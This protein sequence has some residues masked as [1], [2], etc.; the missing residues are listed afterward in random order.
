M[1][2][3]T[4][5]GFDRANYPD[6]PDDKDTLDQGAWSV[7]FDIDWG[8]SQ[9][10]RDMCNEDMRFVM[11][12]GGQ[13]E[14]FLGDQFSTNRPRM[15]MDRT[16]ERVNT[17]M[18][19]YAEAKPSVVFGPATGSNTSTD[20]C[21]ILNGLFR[22]DMRRNNGYYAVYNAVHEAVLGGMGA[23]RVRPKFEDEED[24]TNI[25]QNICFE[26]IHSAYSSV[27]WDANAKRYDK[28]D[29]RHCNIITFM[30]TSAFYERYGDNV[31]P[32]SVPVG[33]DRRE[34]NWNTP[35]GVFVAERYWVTTQI[36]TSILLVHPQTQEKVSLYEEDLKNTIA[37]LDAAGFEEVSRR[38]K[39][40]RTIQKAVYSGVQLLEGPYEVAG[41]WIPIVPVY[42]FWVYMDAQE[43]YLG[44]IR[45]QKDPQRLFNTQASSLAELA[46]TSIKQVPI[47]APE[48]MVGP[49]IKE[50][51]SQAHLG[52]YN[53]M[54]ANP[55]RNEAGE[56][57]T[58]GPIGKIDPPAVDPAI[59]AILEL[60]SSYIK[61]TGDMIPTELPKREISGDAVSKL[62]KRVDLKTYLIMENI[63]NSLI[64]CGDIY[65]DMATLIYSDTRNVNLLAEDD[66][67]S[68]TLINGATFDPATG[69][70]TYAN[71]VANKRFECYA[72]I[73]P[74]FMSMRQEAKETMLGLLA[75][76]DKS[77][78][79]YTVLLAEYV[80]LLDGSTEALTEF[81]RKQMLKLGL[82]KPETPEEEQMMDN[83]A[84]QQAEPSPEEQL[85]IAATENEKAQAQ[86]N[87]ADVGVKNAQAE[88]N[89]AKSAEALASAEEKQMGAFERANNVLNFDQ[90]RTG[91]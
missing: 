36:K 63:Y 66:T 44:L 14:G 4:R 50:Q 28:R 65:K 67:Q 29:A 91:T 22:A 33:E 27:I 78:P 77:S 17:F 69:D 35:D 88:L 70:V 80:N 20:D 2:I 5:G 62:T 16:Y 45:K 74:S 8:S 15:E 60:T 57:I 37:D 13:W 25:N 43:A 79:Y 76:V 24:D 42:A 40:V 61:D 30:T 51:W 87:L 90:T 39:T 81:N 83:L 75:A 68:T 71:Q 6:T 26:P 11:M 47:F 89:K 58:T 53:Y 23:F 85:V 56:I 54:L 46:A 86:E 19:Q 52:K 49:G 32:S 72:N 64:M 38:Q 73:G 84:K 10:Q 59:A 34:F 1:A 7:E 18:S 12:Q 3:T 31:S 82:R 48:Q 9:Q 41:K 55:L 21:R